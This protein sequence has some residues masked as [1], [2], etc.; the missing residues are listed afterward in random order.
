[1]IR[2][3]VVPVIAMALLAGC[4]HIA[5]SSLPRA[6][7]R[8]AYAAS[9][10]ACRTGVQELGLRGFANRVG[11]PSRRPSVVAHAAVRYAVPYVRERRPGYLA[12]RRAGYLG[13]VAGIRAALR[14]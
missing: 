14:R 4:G 10:R 7:A 2:R 11:A 5:L 13:C 3:I 8:H 1:M 12:Y 9:Y 6:S